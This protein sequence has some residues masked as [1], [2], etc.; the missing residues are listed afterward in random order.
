MVVGDLALGLA[1][2]SESSCFADFDLCLFLTS[3]C[4][5][6][7][8]TVLAISTVFSSQQR[9]FEVIDLDAPLYSCIATCKIL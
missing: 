9:D 6:L 5:C 4:V 7:V 3:S 1:L 2:L 8:N